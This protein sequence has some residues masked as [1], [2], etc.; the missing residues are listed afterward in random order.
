MYIY[1][2]IRLLQRCK[3]WDFHCNFGLYDPHEVIEIALSKLL[4]WLR[5]VLHAAIYNTLIHGREA[6]SLVEMRHFALKP[7]WGSA[8]ETTRRDR[9]TLSGASGVGRSH[10]SRVGRDRVSRRGPHPQYHRIPLPPRLIASQVRFLIE[11][12]WER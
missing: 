11:T 7:A 3:P 4:L 10:W 1:L 8:L 2:Y 6:I 12:S 9:P 5:F